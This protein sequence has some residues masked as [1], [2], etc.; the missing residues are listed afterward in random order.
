MRVDGDAV[1][2]EIDDHRPFSHQHLGEDGHVE[3]HGAQI[4]AAA[5]N[6]LAVG[7][8]EIDDTERGIA[9]NPIALVEA[10]GVRAF[11]HRRL[12]AATVRQTARADR[13]ETRVWAEV[14][15]RVRADAVPGGLAAEGILGAH[16]RA[17]I[18]VFAAGC[19]VVLAAVAG[20]QAASTCARCVGATRSGSFEQTAQR[21]ALLRRNAVDALRRGQAAE[22]PRDQGTAPS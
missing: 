12:E 17:A 6:D 18:D 7:H 3:E 13:G 10:A 22:R 11:L 9:G 4:I 15:R 21:I 14:E 20:S 5:R 1:N 16:G 8:R 19:A 2:L